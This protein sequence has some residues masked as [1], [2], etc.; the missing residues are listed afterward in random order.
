L[1]QEK[2]LEVVRVKK[3]LVTTLKIQVASTQPPLRTFSF[4]ESS[5]IHWFSTP[6][7]AGDI[8][9]N[10][11]IT[12]SVETHFSP[13]Q[14]ALEN[15]QL[16]LS[17]TSEGALPF[18]KW[19]CI[20]FTLLLGGY[21]VLVALRKKRYNLVFLFILGV[22]SLIAFFIIGKRNRLSNFI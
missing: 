17:P 3:W 21:K 22:V 10:T 19:F 4:L 15:E 1:I 2:Y 16:L 7:S 20:A 11:H 12:Q 5:L 18:L 8:F 14:E 9:S 6:R 13:Y